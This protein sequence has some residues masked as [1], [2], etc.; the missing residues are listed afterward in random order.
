MT[1]TVLP[2]VCLKHA[3]SEESG[4]KSDKT[5]IGIVGIGNLAIGFI[6]L[7]SA[8][9]LRA[10]RHH[11][12][13]L[14]FFRPVG[15]AVHRYLHLECKAGRVSSANILLNH[16]NPNIMILTKWSA[17]TIHH[18]N[19]FYEIRFHRL[20]STWFHLG[21]FHHPLWNLFGI[22]QLPAYRAHIKSILVLLQF[23]YHDLVFWVRESFCAVLKYL[24][25]IAEGI[26]DD[27][28]HQQNVTQQDWA[29]RAMFHL[30]RSYIHDSLTQSPARVAVGCQRYWYG[31]FWLYFCSSRNPGTLASILDVAEAM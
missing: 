5:D 11:L 6:F 16:N 30:P 3:E 29:P 4:I 28:Y 24:I 10:W 31:G 8:L 2:C 14:P 22:P 18:N 7:P 19:P 12:F 15:N 23:N 25:I 27:A 13:G 26:K 17:I 21:H 20:A 1:A 9:R